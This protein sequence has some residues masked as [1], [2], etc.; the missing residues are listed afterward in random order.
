[1]Q[2]AF[3]RN[4]DSV[5]RVIDKEQPIPNRCGFEPE[6]TSPLSAGQTACYSPALA[7]RLPLKKNENVWNDAG[8]LMAVAGGLA[9]RSGAIAL[10]VVCVHRIQKVRNRASGINGVRKI[11]L[12]ISLR[13]DRIKTVFRL[14]FLVHFHGSKVGGFHRLQLNKSDIDEAKVR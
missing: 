6:A 9:P 11:V 5:R 8:R 14:V 2:W 7:A 3:G 13:F 10:T 1:M 12:F 4:T